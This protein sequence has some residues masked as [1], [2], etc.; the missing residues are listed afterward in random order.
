MTI[1]PTP[2]TRGVPT[3]QPSS[4]PEPGRPR[5]GS[6]C[7]PSTWATPTTEAVEQ[8]QPISNRPRDSGCGP[9]RSSRSA[10][11]K[12]TTGATMTS[13]PMIQRTPLARVTPTGPIPLLH[14]AAPMT[15]ASPR[16]ARPTPSRRC[17][18][19]SGSV[20]SGRAT[21]RARPPAPRASRFQLPLAARQRLNPSFFLR[22]AGRRAVE[23]RLAG[24]RFLPAAVAP[25]RPRA[26]D[27]DAAGR[28]VDVLRAGMCR[29]VIA[30]GASAGQ[31]GDV[32]PTR[33]RGPLPSQH[34][35]PPPPRQLAHPD[36]LRA[37]GP[38]GGA[39]RRGGRRRGRR[40]VVGGAPGRG[41]P[42][43]DRPPERRRH[44]HRRPPRAVERPHPR[45]RVR[46]RRVDGGR[47]HAVVHRVLRPAAVPARARQRGSGGGD[48]RTGHPGRRPAR[49]SPRDA[50]RGARGPGD[51]PRG[52][53]G[54]RRRQRDRAGGGR[55]R[56][57]GARLRSR[58][59]LRP[60]AR[61][62]RRHVVLVAVGAPGHAVGLRAARGPRGRRHRS[63][64]RRAVPGSRSSSRSGARTWRCGS[65]ATAPTSGR[66]TASARTRGRSSSSTSAATSPARSGC[67]GRVASRCSPTGGSCSPTAATAPTGSPSWRPDGSV[68][69][70]AV[71]VRG[72]PEAHRAGHGG[73]LRRRRSGQRARRPAG[74]RRRRASRRSSARPA[75]SAWTAHGSPGPST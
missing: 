33:S 50:R 13:E 15:T 2:A 35:F 8:I 73:R 60:P 59:R 21:E 16:T 46:R 38:G 47:R 49:R 5:W 40:V 31:A 29:T 9:L 37:G 7:S 22:A 3:A 51:A 56:H 68:R 66:S 64:A 11:K 72:V 71:A 61:A 10:A 57:R 69:E 4:P 62:G 67:S 27:G 24:G 43:G 74:R 52:R 26:L 17:S 20:S 53:P 25:E 28:R 32:S 45:A 42:D 55:R 63:R 44:G 70:L 1:G 19:A 36:R 75:T 54:R 23:D 6:A 41:R 30:P 65:S 18:G 48:T 58:L 34:G 12:R 14:A 39:A